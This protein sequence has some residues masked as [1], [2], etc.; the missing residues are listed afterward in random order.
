VDYLLNGPG[1]KDLYDSER[2]ALRNIAYA[3]RLKHSFKGVETVPEEERLKASFTREIRNRCGEIGLIVDVEWVWDDIDEKTG[4]LKAQS[5]DVS[6]DPGDNNLYWLPRIIVTGRTDKL[7]EYDHDKQQ[8]EVTEGIL[9]GDP[10]YIR[11][12]G[13]LREDPKK[14]DIY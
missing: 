8:W 10:G 3:M 7:P 5:P 12:D 1:I 4:E 14:R 11:E 2:K 13:S 9:D 6:D